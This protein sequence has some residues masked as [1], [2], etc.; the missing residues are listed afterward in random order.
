MTLDRIQILERFNKIL[1]EERGE[2]IALIEDILE[3]TDET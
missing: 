3:A 2:L 1:L